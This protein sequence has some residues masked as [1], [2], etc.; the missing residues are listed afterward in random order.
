MARR[1]STAPLSFLHTHTYPIYQF[2]MTMEIPGQSAEKCLLYAGLTTYEWLREKA[3]HDYP[4]E[5]D[6]PPASEYLSANPSVM[7]SVHINEGYSLDI[8]SL[9]DDGMWAL[10]IREPESESSGKKP[11]VGRTIVTNIGFKTISDTKIECGIL[12]ESVDPEDCEEELR[13]GFRPAIVRTMLLNPDVKASS[14]HQIFYDKPTVI[15]TSSQLNDLFNLITSRDNCQPITIFTYA[16]E[17]RD[18]ISIITHLDAEL[19]LSGKDK[20]IESLIAEMDFPSEVDIG[21][22]TMPYDVKAYKKHTA[23]YGWTFVIDSS[24]MTEYQARMHVEISPGDILWIEPRRFG[25]DSKCFPY[26]D[27]EHKWQKDNIL[28]ELQ[29]LTYEYS[30]GKTIPFGDIKYE[31]DLRGIERNK[32]IEEVKKASEEGLTELFDS[33][34]EKILSLQ[35][36]IKQLEQQKAYYESESKRL[37]EEKYNSTNLVAGIKVD[38]ITELYSGEIYDLVISS[39]ICMKDKHCTEGSRKEEL[40]NKLL[41]LNEL[42]GKG[43]S[44]FDGLKKVLFQDRNLTESDYS[45]LKKYGFEVTKTHG[46]HYK[47]VFLNDEKRHSM[48]P[49]TGSDHRGLKN[50]YSEII[51][52][53]SI[54]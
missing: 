45:E 38:G 12:I 14:E 9:P 15:R 39:L 13:R 27:I 23:G 18:L 19:G 36:E 50:A 46:G 8:T 35:A 20:S 34:E 22:V 6:T 29:N 37:Y 21:A 53:E 44:Y 40:L 52:R 4:P 1:Q 24:I 47:I 17:K 30:K 28:E 51:N 5:F 25:G 41:D 2:Y 33:Q 7:K 43:K 11:I 54:Y 31:P 42:Q 48:L 49:A 3:K 32:R 16:S 10:K 26:L